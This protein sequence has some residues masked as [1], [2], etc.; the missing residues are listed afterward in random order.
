MVAVPPTC[1]FQSTLRS[2]SIS[3]SSL[4]CEELSTVRFH[5]NLVFPVVVRLPVKFTFPVNPIAQF[6]PVIVVVAIEFDV[7]LVAV[8]F[9]SV[10]LPVTVRVQVTSVSPHISTS[11]VVV[12][13]PRVVS[14]VTSKSP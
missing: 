6:C 7:V 3:T 10:V 5:C 2:S 8:T 9:P 13:F 11:H 12:T 14:H 1:R 4:K